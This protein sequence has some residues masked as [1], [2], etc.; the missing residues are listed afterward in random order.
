[1]TTTTLAIPDRSLSG[2]SRAASTAFNHDIDGRLA[3]G[4]PQGIRIQ[5]NSVHLEFVRADI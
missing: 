3:I 5:D 2:L 1:M 4:N